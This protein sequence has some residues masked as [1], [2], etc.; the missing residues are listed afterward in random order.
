M[1]LLS[2]ILSVIIQLARSKAS[3]GTECWSHANGAVA[4]GCPPG[5]QCGSWQ[6]ANGG[7]W[8]G[9]SPW[10]CLYN[11]KRTRGQSC[12]YDKKQGK[13]CVILLHNIL[14]LKPLSC[15]HT[16]PQLVQLNHCHCKLWFR[17]LWN[18]I[19]LSQQ[20]LWNN[21]QIQ[22]AEMEQNRN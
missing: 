2:I 12:N 17:H 1:V 19:G 7:K 18:G 14:M 5:T 6:V 9:Q 16:R 11:S 21:W 3:V 8:D 10:Y 22:L 15:V 20:H 13:F 4:G